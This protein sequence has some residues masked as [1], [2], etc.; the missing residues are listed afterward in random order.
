VILKLNNAR[1]KTE[2]NPMTNPSPTPPAT[3]PISPGGPVT[4][5]ETPLDLE[6]IAALP[7]LRGDQRDARLASIAAAANVDNGLAI[8]MARYSNDDVRWLCA[9]LAEAHA[10]GEFDSDVAEGHLMRA[11]AAEA[12]VARL[13]ER[14][15][16]LISAK[17]GD[18]D[19]LR[20]E[21]DYLRAARD[22]ALGRCQQP[23]QCHNASD[24]AGD[25]EAREPQVAAS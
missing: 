2:G 5:T 7:I 13:R 18:L 1:E 15:A 22:P 21:R 20:D 10:S 24:H 23:M 25:H 11:T 14:E 8:Q 12:E 19:D 6:V 16:A 4:T 9:Q 3:T 17:D